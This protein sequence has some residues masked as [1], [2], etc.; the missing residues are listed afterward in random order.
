[1]ARF[2]VIV[3]ILLGW[4]LVRTADAG[5]LR[6]TCATGSCGVPMRVSVVV[7]APA[8]VKQAAPTGCSGTVVMRTPL[9][10]PRATGCSGVVVQKAAPKAACSGAVVQRAP[11][12]PLQSLIQNHQVKKAAK[13]SCG[14]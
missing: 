12:R 13:G 14:G 9:L 5:P 7:Q 11:I 1:M 8:P 4:A 3:C 10:A 2:L 6:P